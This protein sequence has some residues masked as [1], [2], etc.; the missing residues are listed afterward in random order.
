M[1]KWLMSSI[2]I[3]SPNPIK[4][5]I[6]KPKNEIW[7]MVIDTG[8][9]KHNKLTSVVYD[10]SDDYIDKNG[11]GTHVAGLIQNGIDNLKLCPQVKI[12]SCKFFDGAEWKGANAISDCVRKASSLNMDYINV[13]AGGTSFIADEYEAFKNFKGTVFAAAGNDG[14]ELNNSYQ[15]YPA[16]YS[17]NRVKYGLNKTSEHLKNIK[18][19]QN[20][21]NG[22][23]I[24]SSNYKIGLISEC[25]EDAESTY[26]NN[27]YRILSGT[28]QATAIALHKELLKT[29][30]TFNGGNYGK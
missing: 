5:L 14:N 6:E 17:Y 29:C 11:H 27:S 25:G 10:N 8:V 30:S 4:I 23:R 12:F 3:G 13:S 2:I 22:V 28:S 19:I 20:V 7:V 18:V 1:F 9:S 26:L 16:S 24:K 21:C 15:Y